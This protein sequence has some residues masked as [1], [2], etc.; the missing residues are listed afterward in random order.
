MP[1]QNSLSWQSYYHH[2]AV[3]ENIIK[4][5]TEEGK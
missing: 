5:Q 1:T 2:T 4:N 3:Y